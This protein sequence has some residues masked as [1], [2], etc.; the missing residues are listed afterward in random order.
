MSITTETATE[1]NG[2]SRCR[3]RPGAATSINKACQQLQVPRLRDRTLRAVGRL[4][5][6]RRLR[7]SLCRALL[8]RGSLGP[9]VKANV[10][11]SILFK[12]H[13]RNARDYVPASQKAKSPKN[14]D[15]TM[16]RLRFSK[17]SKSAF[18]PSLSS[19]RHRPRCP[20]RQRQ[21]RARYL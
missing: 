17:A 11:H 21:A 5:M 12:L 14:R 4:L 10:D 13:F 20:P 1:G 6:A 15:R 2:C 8:H 7:S 18:S 3:V 19:V 9:G 16:R